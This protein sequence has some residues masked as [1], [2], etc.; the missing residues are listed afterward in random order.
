[1][2]GDKKCVCLVLPKGDLTRENSVNQGLIC[3]IPTCSLA[4]RPLHCLNFKYVQVI[5]KWK[6]TSGKP[7]GQGHNMPTWGEGKSSRLV[8]YLL[9][10][11]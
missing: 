10:I 3:D 1:M 4:H 9:I 8:N 6:V 11:H 7:C 5:N 2:R